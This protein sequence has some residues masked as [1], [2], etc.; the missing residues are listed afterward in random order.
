[1]AQV[2]TL[3][4]A[5]VLGAALVGGTIALDTR[6]RAQDAPSAPNHDDV[7]YQRFGCNLSAVAKAGDAVTGISVTIDPNDPNAAGW[8]AWLDSNIGTAVKV[9]MSSNTHDGDDTGTISDNANGVATIDLDNPGTP[10]FPTD[11]GTRLRLFYVS[12]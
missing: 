9:S 5:A 10:Q 8:Q 7:Q 2:R 11:L 12:Q 4:T 3:F 6:A 1:M